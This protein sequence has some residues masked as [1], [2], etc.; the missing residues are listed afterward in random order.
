[1]DACIGQPEVCHYGGGVGRSLLG[2][3]RGA[4]ALLVAVVV[5]AG[6]AFAQGS[7][8]CPGAGTAPMP[9]EIAGTAVP[10][11]VPSTTAD[12]F[13]L[14]VRHEIDADTTA[15]IHVNGA[16]DVVLRENVISGNDTH[17]VSLAETTQ[18]QGECGAIP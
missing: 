17:G 16:R 11:A 5:L 15:G 8:T 6:L 2:P 7:D 3:G 1:M 14:Y 4:L 10:I 9:V 13:V 12:Y 18:A